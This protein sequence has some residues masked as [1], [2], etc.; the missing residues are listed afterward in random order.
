MTREI[1]TK[2]LD[3]IN[4]DTWEYGS[5]IGSFFVR[6]N[7]TDEH[8]MHFMAMLYAE[9]SASVYTSTD[10]FGKRVYPKMLKMWKG[11]LDFY[12]SQAST[13]VHKQEK[14]KK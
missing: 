11:P 14:E 9:I 4:K 5:I 2:T 3:K 10:N 8:A 7:Y 1:D 13:W 12:C 6:N